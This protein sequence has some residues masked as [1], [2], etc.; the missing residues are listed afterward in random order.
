LFVNPL[1]Q[2]QVAFGL[3]QCAESEKLSE[4]NPLGVEFSPPLCKYLTVS[5]PCDVRNE[6]VRIHSYGKD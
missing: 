5:L 2:A 1:S 4:N 6:Q 3:S